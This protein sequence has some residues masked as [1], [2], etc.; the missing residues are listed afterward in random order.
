MNRVLIVTYPK[1]EAKEQIA[2]VMEAEYAMTNS[3]RDQGIIEHLFAK[4]ND[5][6]GIVVFNATSVEKV[7]ELV[8]QLPLFPFFERVEYFPLNKIY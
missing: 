2:A 6:G 7:Q 3:W 1:Q 4:E 5:G 8:A